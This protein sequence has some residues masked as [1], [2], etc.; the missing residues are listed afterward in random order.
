M[1]ALFTSYFFNGSVHLND[2]AFRIAGT[3]DYNVK[4]MWTLPYVPGQRY[5]DKEV[6][7]LTSQRTFSA[8]E[9]FTYDLQALKRATVVGETTAGGAN[10][11]G[12]YRVGDHF[13]AAMPMGHSVNPVTKTNWEGKGIAPD[14]KVPEKNALT[15]AQRVA[16]QH[17]VEKTTDQQALAVLKKALATLDTDR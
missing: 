2:L 12:P 11:G 10:P 5:V 16:L 1:L 17:L 9:E 6:Y 4:Q 15:A 8:A 7:V 14:I 3:K 13:Y